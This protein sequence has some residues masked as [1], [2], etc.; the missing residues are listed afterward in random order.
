M[1]SEKIT[2]ARE[3]VFPNWTT[4][5]FITLSNR[6]RAFRCDNARWECWENT[7]E[8]CINKYTWK[9]NYAE[10]IKFMSLAE[11]RNFCGLPKIKTFMLKGKWQ[12]KCLFSHLK[13]LLK[14]YLNFFCRFFTPCLVL[15]LFSLSNEMS[16][17][18]YTF[19]ILLR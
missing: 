7:R 15:E 1:E 16:A 3:F 12:Y 14:L 19:L 4:N 9:N 17:I 2:F 13:E 5:H 8:V 18:L 6:K 10:V 11:E